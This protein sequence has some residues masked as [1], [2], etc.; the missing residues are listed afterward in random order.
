MKLHEYQGKNVFK[1]FEIPVP[2]GRMAATAEGAYEAGLQLKGPPWVVK[3]QVHAGGRGKGGGV[4]VVHSLEELQNAAAH[5][6]ET[7]LVTKQ[8]GSQGKKVH[9]VLVEEGLQID[10]ELYLA[11]V[12]DR[13]RALPWV[14][15]RHSDARRRSRR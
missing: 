15:R 1:G 14:R 13:S 6:L 3:A 4:K 10:R 2:E 8:T 7:P 5:I 9:Q 12:L 11:V